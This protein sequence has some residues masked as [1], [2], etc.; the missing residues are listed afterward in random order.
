MYRITKVNNLC[1]PIH[2][3]LQFLTVPFAL[4]CGDLCV[5]G[6][7]KIQYESPIFFAFHTTDLYLYLALLL[8]IYFVIHI[9]NFHIL[10][11][12]TLHLIEYWLNDVFEI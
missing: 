4:A 5:S 11:W 9:H 6:V 8:H 10:L 7:S 2:V 12:Q 3:E 1:N